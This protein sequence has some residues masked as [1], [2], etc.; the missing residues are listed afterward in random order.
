MRY[1]LW[2]LY[3][4]NRRIRNGAFD[5]WMNKITHFGGARFT[6]A[7]SL[8]LWFSQIG[9]QAVAALAGSHV[10]VHI[11][12]KSFGRQRPYLA[13]DNLFVV[14]DPLIDNSFPSGHSTAI[15][16]VATVI[17][18]TFPWLAIIAFPLALTVGLSRIYLGLHYPSDVIVGA[19]IGVIFAE[20]AHLL[21]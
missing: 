16:S 7:L 19:G 10:L 12:K 5:R 15:F 4:L 17:A 1:E 18:L 11:L 2:L 3:F 21:L 9:S 20:F 13:C 8:I 14:E 6:I